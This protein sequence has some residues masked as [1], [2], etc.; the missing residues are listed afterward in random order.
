MKDD[1][2]KSGPLEAAPTGRL[3]IRLFRRF[4]AR[5]VEG[6]VEAGFDDVTLAH[7]SVL[8][9]LDL[10]GLRISALARDAGVTKQAMGQM[11]KEL[12]GR[13]YIRVGPD[14]TDGRAKLVSYSKE[15]LRLIM[16]AREVVADLERQ[17][18]HA[19]GEDS[20]H[21]MRQALIALIE[22]HST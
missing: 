13:G 2:S 15:G 14:P 5:V 11:V 21:Q 6:L 8:R 3:L 7:L 1:E 10:E 20:Y 17:Y 4:E 16:T 22:H 9:H 18:R 19:L 12:V